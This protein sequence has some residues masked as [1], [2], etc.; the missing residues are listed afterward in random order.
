MFKKC[1]FY[2]SVATM[3]NYDQGFIFS[4]SNIVAFLAELEEYI[5]A[6]ITY[7]AFK[8]DDPQAAIAAIPLEKLLPKDYTKKELAIQAPQQPDDNVLDG[9]FFSDGQVI[10]DEMVHIDGKSVYA[11]FK[12]MLKKGDADGAA[13]FHDSN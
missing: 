12:K 13:H 10:D 2:L 9:R 3:M 4:E 1:K 5:C 6:L 11:N 7:T 8:R